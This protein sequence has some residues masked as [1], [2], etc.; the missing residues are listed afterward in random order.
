[1]TEGRPRPRIGRSRLPWRLRLLT[2][3]ALAR[4]W[5]VVLAL[6]GLLATVVARAI[7]T[8][9][10]AQRRWGDG[11]TVVV[12]AHDLE[13]GAPLD[14]DALREVRWPLALIPADALRRAPPPGSTAS[15]AL[16]AGV[17]ITEGAVR[18]PGRS[19]GRRTVALA[20]S[21][22]AL[23]VEVGDRVDIWSIEDPASVPDGTER[24][25]RVARGAEVVR[26]I[27]GGVVVALDADEVEA[28]AA[29]TAPV[30]LVG[31]P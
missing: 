11:A 26:T 9:E 29:A 1:M 31:S 12:A 7:A 18:D 10:Q 8:A 2:D 21:S 17:S 19:D 3:P 25:D 16:A 24:A 30:V 23:P 6:A 13:A 28:T 27:E 14:G 20:T 4:H 22:A 5:L 15:A